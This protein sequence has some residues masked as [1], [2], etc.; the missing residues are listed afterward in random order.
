MKMRGFRKLAVS[1]ILLMCCTA[2][3]ADGFSVSTNLVGYAW[4]GTLNA[5]GSYAFD[6]KW[7]VTAGVEYNPWTFNSSDVS[8][9]FQSRQL[10][11]SAGVRFWPWHV[12]S[13]WWIAGKMKYQEYNIGGIV[14]RR[15]EEGDRAGAGISA[16]YTYML[17][18]NL[19][20]EFGLGLWGGVKWY[21]EYS[22]PACGRTL[23]AGR[24]GF[25]LPDN[26]TISISYVF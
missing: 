7:S 2:A 26:L 18:H 12:Y 20:I 9:Q 17:R 22:C 4:L 13:G 14:S 10:A 5:E 23:D 1:A 19:N 3:M 25:I 15:T 16:G 8:R 21:R 11:C 24:K 6:R